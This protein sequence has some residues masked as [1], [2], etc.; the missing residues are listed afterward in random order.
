MPGS[1]VGRPV[2]MLGAAHLGDISVG[3]RTASALRRLGTPYVD[4]L[5]PRPFLE[6]QA[7]LDAANPTGR[8]YYWSSQYLAE[9]DDR[10]L[11]L[12]V[13][14][15]RT[16]SAPGSLIALFQL[17]GALPDA[18]DRSC[19]PFRTATL[20][21]NYGTQWT[22]PAEDDHH[23]A[24]TRARVHEVAR[25]G[26]GAGYTNFDGDPTATGD[27]SFPPETLRRLVALKRRWDPDNVF[28]HNVN[29]AP[30]GPGQR[31]STTSE[32]AIAQE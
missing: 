24:W 17:G 5:A 4:T 32:M 15:A 20:L 21:V 22:D 19:A 8:R 3:L 30:D 2:I 12:V 13:G 18:A 14:H 26:A 31:V 23:R 16:L 6:H 1:V 9:P 27:R 11:D 29:I 7:V 28:H 10:L 25:Y